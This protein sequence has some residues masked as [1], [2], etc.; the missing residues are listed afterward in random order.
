M[1]H[2]DIATTMNIYAEVPEAKKK[3][4]MEALAEKDGFIL[5]L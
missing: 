5:K 2:V 4:S 1:G 3:A